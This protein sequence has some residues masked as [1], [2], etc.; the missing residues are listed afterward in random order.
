MIVRTHLLAIRVQHSSK[1]GTVCNGVCAPH[2]L[3]VEPID[4]DHPS[5]LGVAL[6]C[7]SLRQLIVLA[8]TDV[9][10][11]AGAHITDSFEL[12]SLARHEV[13]PFLR[14][15]RRRLN[16]F[17]ICRFTLRRAANTGVPRSR[18]EANWQR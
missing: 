5:R 13:S 11:G 1:A 14:N 9:G 6:N 16:F 4:D 12:F 15:C 17:P 3:I 18:C 2:R 8:L 7:L 10:R